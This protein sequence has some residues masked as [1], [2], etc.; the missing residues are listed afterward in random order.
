M[1]WTSKFRAVVEFSGMSAGNVPSTVS[2]A[3]RIFVRLMVQSDR[4]VVCPVEPGIVRE[5]SVV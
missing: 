5:T 2:R 4:Y 3:N 1:A